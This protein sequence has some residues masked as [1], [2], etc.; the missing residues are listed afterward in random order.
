MSAGPLV[1]IVTPCLNPGERLVRCLDSIAAQT[2]PHIEHLVVDGGSTDGTVEILRERGVAFVS[3]PDRGQSHAINKGFAL[4]R[5]EWLGWLNADDVLTPCA[6]DLA[7]AAIETT[8][9]AGWV[10]GDCHMRHEGD[11]YDLWKPP[12]H[13]ELETLDNGNLVAQPGS[14]VARWALERVGPLA[15]NLELVMDYDLWLRLLGAGVSSVYVPETL[16]VFEIHEGSKSGSIPFSEF[17]LEKAVSLAKQGRARS[18]AFL[19][20]RA[21][22]S[23]ACEGDRIERSELEREIATLGTRARRYEVEIEMR[24]FRARAYAEA[25][26]IELHGKPRG[27]RHLLRH[28]PWLVRETRATLVRSLVG[29]ASRRLRRRTAARISSLAHRRSRLRS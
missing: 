18:A 23:A 1:S 16:S 10:Y 11:R 8:P 28:E 22:A 6:V 17:Y 12:P 29:G 2:Y 15:E 26:L 13:L 3:E 27:Y 24:W 7:V 25:V 14:L 4:A 21:A 20:G 19:L 5:G 9:H